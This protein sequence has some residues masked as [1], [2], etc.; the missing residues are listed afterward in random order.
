M[1]LDHEGVRERLQEWVVWYRNRRQ[2]RNSLTRRIEAVE[3]AIAGLN[4]EREGY[5]IQQAML[6]NKSSHTIARDI[7]V[8]SYRVREITL[9]AFDQLAVRIEFCDRE[10][11]AKV[12]QC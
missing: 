11:A 6:H 4:S 8:E 2:D 5:V 1:R 10:L 12:E 3:K 7:G 9:A